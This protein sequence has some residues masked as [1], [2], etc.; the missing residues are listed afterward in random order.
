MDEPNDF[1]TDNLMVRCTEV[2]N[3]K[4]PDCGHKNKYQISPPSPKKWLCVN[5]GSDSFF[6]VGIDEDGNILGLLR[7]GDVIK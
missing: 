7:D 6:K 4:C 1:S 3:H 2:L 5:C